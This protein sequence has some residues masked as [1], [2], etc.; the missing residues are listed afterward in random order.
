MTLDKSP[1]AIQLRGAVQERWIVVERPSESKATEIAKLFPEIDEGEA[2]AI[3]LAI[4]Q[5][6]ENVVI[7]DA[8]ARIAAEYFKLK[9]YGTLYVILEAYKRNIFKS[10]VDVRSILD[11]MLRKGFYLSTEVYARFLFLLDR[12]R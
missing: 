11:N 1:E 7:D 6:M 4:E 9:V 10:K 12:T 3:A 8:E 5:Q 2:A